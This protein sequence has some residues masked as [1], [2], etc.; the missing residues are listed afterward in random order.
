MGESADLGVLLVHGIGGQRR[1]DTLLDFGEPLTQSLIDWLDADTVELHDTE[2]AQA[3]A[4]QPAHL[5]IT[6]RR[7]EQVRRVLVA[8]SWWAEVFHPPGWWAFARWLVWGVPFVIFRAADH[9]ISVIDTNEKLDDA[10]SSRQWRDWLRV[11]WYVAVRLLKNIVSV[12]LVAVA[13]VVLLFG[14]IVALVP[15]VRVAILSGQ[16]VLIR[17]LG[18]SYCLVTSPVRAEAT[19]SQVERDLEWLE[20][21]GAAKVAIFAHSQGAEIVRRVVAR[22][23]GGWPI[24]SLITFGAG[25]AKLRAVG[26]LHGRKWMALWAYAL[27]A[28]AAVV[29]V[30]GPLLA[31]RAD[32]SGFVT[33]L[34]ALAAVAAAGLLITWARRILQAIVRAGELADELCVVGADKLERWLDFYATSDPVPEGALP[35]QKLRLKAAGSTRIANY[36]SPLRDHMS[37]P[38][39]GEAFRPAVL[40]ELAGLVGWTFRPPAM[41][42]VHNSRERR[43]RKT[44]TL[45]AER[46][47]LGL[48]AIAAVVLPYGF[49]VGRELADDVVNW[50]SERAGW[51]AQWLGEDAQTWLDTAPGKYVVAAAAVVLAVCALYGL[52]ASLWSVSAQRRARRLLKPSRPPGAEALGETTP[53][54]LRLAYA[55][56]AKHADKID[57]THGWPQHPRR[58]RWLMPRLRGEFVLFGLRYRLRQENLYDTAAPDPPKRVK[59]TPRVT[60]R[61]FDGKGTDLCDPEMGAAETHFGRNAPAF[62]HRGD[63]PS[64]EQI[65]RDLLARRGDK[66]LAADELNLLAAAWV[67]FE[68]HDWMQHRQQSMWRHVRDGPLARNTPP[69]ERRDA[70][71]TGAPRFVSAQTHWWDASQLY[72]VDPTFTQSLRAGDGSV[73]TGEALL[74]AIEASM[75]GSPAPVP[76]F[77]LGLALFHELFAREHNTICEALRASEPDLEGDAL[78]DTAR[79]VNGALMAKIHTIEWTPAVTAHPTTAHAIL[80][81]WWGLLGRRTRRS[82]GRIGTGEVLSG[83]PGSRTHHDGV[84]YS[85]TEEFVAVY[86]MHPLIPDVVTF[87]TARDR[88]TLATI[89]FGDLAVGAGPPSR[90]R[91]R[92]EEIGVANAFY[93]LGVESPGQITLH[94]Y[95]GFLRALPLPGGG[96]VDL[97][98]RDIERMREAALP[99]YNDFRRLFRLAP[100]QTFVDL[101]GGRQELA[102]E[103]E[104][105]YGDLEAVDLMVGLFAEPSPEGLAFSDT[106]FRVF[107]LMAARRLRSDRFFTSDFTPAVYTRTGYRWVQ[108]RTMKQMLG[109]HFPA[110]LSALDGVDNVF[111]PWHAR[112]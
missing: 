37:Y 71:R 47:A 66:F 6:I 27:R 80:A 84:R 109:Q 62:P 106:A 107:L 98:Q 85:L 87:R 21:Q 74:E 42:V 65:S 89:P 40:A 51:A 69:F 48:G 23:T 77:W 12:V 93:S 2:L 102:D 58:L 50:L 20:D 11:P 61:T 26:R 112:S 31:M 81:T 13:I 60:A 22:R 68:V 78:F 5:R 96:H 70:V 90:P 4:G 111:K 59:V 43:E 55:R 95:P 44:R 101:T 53:F 34:V 63:L 24:A 45:V 7:G 99:R 75:G 56:V 94:N 10:R 104:A 103:I 14:G 30:A 82:V 38:H 15:R 83:I 52:G 100:R 57:R 46:L 110:L 64:A 35:L 91:E 29:T 3:S 8:E 73:K 88:G 105:V 17:Y 28:V 86:R 67:Q 79:L 18:D 108:T 49:D 36:R 1:G 72:G 54:V 32:L 97:A 33:V 41:V 39:N 9:G 76:N 25:I 16:R 92:L 19:L